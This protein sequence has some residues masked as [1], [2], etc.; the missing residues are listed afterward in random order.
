M[1]DEIRGEGGGTVGKGVDTETET[2]A[3]LE[4]LLWRVDTT[5]LVPPLFVNSSGLMAI[6]TPSNVRES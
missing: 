1:G 2:D 5:L 3:K 4:S 6:S